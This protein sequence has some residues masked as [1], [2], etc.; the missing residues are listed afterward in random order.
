MSLQKGVIVKST[1]P[2]VNDDVDKGFFVGFR[3]IDDSTTPA[4][5]YICIDNTAAA[6]DWSSGLNIANSSA[7]SSP[8]RSFGVTYTPNVNRPTLV[9]VTFLLTYSNGNSS[10]VD[11]LINGTQRARASAS[12][13]ILLAGNLT[14]SQTITFVV[15]P[16]QTYR[17][18]N[19]GGGGTE[20]ITFISELTL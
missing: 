5:V 3:W 11:I 9:V 2:T 8:A 7:Y 19:T 10:N 20:A 6:A 18:N 13:A 16:N 1:N 14:S 17:F 12:S 4:T 15:P